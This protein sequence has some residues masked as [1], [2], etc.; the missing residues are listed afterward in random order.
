MV[1]KDENEHARASHFMGDVCLWPKADI[2]MAAINVRFR[3]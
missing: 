3:R 2:A 1:A